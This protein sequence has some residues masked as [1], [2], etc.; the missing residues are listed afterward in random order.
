MCGIIGYIGN[1]NSSEVIIDGLRKMEYRG[2]DSAGIGLWNPNKI[3]VIKSQG[4]IDTIAPSISHNPWKM[5]IGHTRWATHGIPDNINAHPHLS[6]DEK[7]A[8]VHN[9]IIENHNELRT[10]LMERG[11]TFLSQT[12]TEILPHL[13][14]EF[15]KGDFYNAVLSAL[16]LVHGSYGLIAI[17]S[18]HPDEMI[19]ARYGSPVIIGENDCEFIIASDTLAIYPHTNRVIYLKDGEIAHYNSKQNHIN[20]SNLDNQKLDLQYEVLS[21]NIEDTHKGQYSHY[22][23]KE[24]YEQPRSLENA[25][26]GRVKEEIPTVHIDTITTHIKRIKDIKRIVIT[27]CGTSYHAG[28]LGKYYME[29]MLS[30]PVDVEY[31]SEFRYRRRALGADTLVIVISQSGE[32]AD[33][34][35]AM[36]AAKKQGALTLSICNV[37]GSSIARESDGG[38]YLYAG[39]EIG[40]ASTKAYTSQIMNLLIMGI[41]LASLFPPLEE[42]LIDRKNKLLCIPKLVEQTLELFELPPNMDE[43]IQRD[44]Y[45]FL[46]RGYNMATALEGA[47]KLKEIAYIPCTGMP[48]AEMKHG[49]IALVDEY[50]PS[51]IVCPKDYLYDKALSNIQEIQA[52]SG[53]ILAVGTKGDKKLK[54]I[55]DFMFQ[56]PET[57]DWIYPFLTIIPLQLFAFHVALA[58]GRNVDRPRNL[59]KSVTVE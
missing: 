42:E 21:M 37:V 33:T 51:V 48:L 16:K 34:L 14:E 57:E 8:V 24:I 17:H 44:H 18:D 26:R 1:K 43:L 15:Y 45:L 38:L 23:L 6:N 56:V 9:G 59:A 20:I 53:P 19:T 10:Y 35:E 50:T 55:V 2:Y 4:T 58:K 7:I 36:R 30:L 49:T 47:L 31:A 11:H 52:R 39:P 28:L 12:D 40:V 54:E 5:G 32:T 46:G 25:L 27:A 13:I 3:Q 41:A 22:M 29:E